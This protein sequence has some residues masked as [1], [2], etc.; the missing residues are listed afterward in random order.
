MEKAQLI[1]RNGRIFLISRCSEFVEDDEDGHF[2]HYD[3]E[4]DVTDT[5]DREDDLCKIC[6]FG[7]Y[8][9]CLE[10]CTHH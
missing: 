8:P 2:I 4:F 5:A 7:D 10:G 6:K 9:K 3:T 1:K